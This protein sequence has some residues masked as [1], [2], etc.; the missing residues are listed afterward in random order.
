M[1]KVSFYLNNIPHPVI[2]YFK[3]DHLNE[4][5]TIKIINIYLKTNSY[6]NKLHVISIAKTNEASNFYHVINSTF[7]INLINDIQSQFSN[8]N[9]I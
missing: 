4:L 2:F 9:T 1:Y 6:N 8:Q 3:S 7:L 5:E